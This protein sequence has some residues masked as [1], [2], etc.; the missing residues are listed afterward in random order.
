MK[1][2]TGALEGSDLEFGKQ[3][4]IF[5]HRENLENSRKL[6]RMIYKC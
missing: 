4:V 1:N 5:G 2:D 6:T 3:P